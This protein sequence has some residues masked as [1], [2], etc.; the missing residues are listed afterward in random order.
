MKRRRFG[1]F[2]PGF[3]VLS[4]LMLGF[5]IGRLGG[6]GSAATPAPVVLQQVRMLGDLHLVAHQY[7][8][9]MTMESHKDAADWTQ[10]V[11]VLNQM[12]S[13]IVESSTKNS[14]LVT[15]QGS[16]EAGVDLSRATIKQDADTVVV[17]LPQVKIYPA[18]VS[19]VMH[20]H[21]HAFGWDD[22]NLALKA[23]REG[24]RRFERSSLEGGI[25]KTAE[26]RARTQVIALFQSAGVKSL[27]VQFVAE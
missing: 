24:A 27:R 5:G 10:S 1:W 15:V 4:V 17:E 21:K 6:A 12:A 11:P 18:N 9:V 13:Y 16:V 22:R 26:D 23:E 3:I 20:S 14:A 25:L 2:L 7:Q 19:A 8:T